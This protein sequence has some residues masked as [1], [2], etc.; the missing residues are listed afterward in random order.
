MYFPLQLRLTLFY[1]L[2]LGIAL[3]IFGGIVFTQAE[4]R[5]YSDLDNTL[6]SRA[7]SVELG[8]DML[9]MQHQ[10]PIIL[11]SISGS[12]TGGVAIEV[13][14]NQLH[15]LATSTSPGISQLGTGVADLGNSPVPWDRQAAQWVLAHP[16]SDSGEP[17]DMF[18]TVFYEGQHIR[19]YTV[20]NN[21]YG[22]NHIIQTARSEQDIEQS[23]A[24]LRTL[25][26]SGGGLVMVFALLG[27]WFLTRSLLISVRR[28]TTTA[29]RISDSHDFSQR[30]PEQASGGRDELTRLAATFNL[31]LAN[32]EEAYQRQ[33]RF[34]ADASHELRAPI[35]SIRCNLDLLAKTPGIAPEDAEA[36]L[37]DARAEAER[38]GRMVNDLLTL[39]HSDNQQLESR[40]Y[41][42][43]KSI[44]TKKVDLDSLLLE[45]YRQYRPSDNQDTTRGPRIIL[46]DIAPAQVYGD[47]DRLKQIL[48]A[49]LDNAVKY[50]PYEGTVSLSLQTEP[51]SA[52]LQV[53][54]TGIG[55]VPEDQPHIFERFY[56][57]DRARSRDR[58]GSGLGLAIVKSIVEEHGGTI[59]LES[60]P[61]KGSTF[62]VR[63]PLPEQTR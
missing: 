54:D 61:G 20:V 40:A 53:S 26:W 57:A 56:R 41:G 50:T 18:S 48:V 33:Q 34:V 46:Q 35:S 60:V 62:I 5:A 16:T 39:A 3:L 49:L 17:G 31:M 9:A 13:L 43:R 36:A 6:R 12:G 24:N 15:L 25:L 27:G 47:A 8:K 52:L 45:V 14:D 1:A 21:Q 38:M 55:I 59:S 10:P 2:L 29:Q 19:V 42:Y 22:L 7:A 23:L 37:N 63:L 30:V 51:E 4:Q 11:P 44:Y 32:L 28:I 58:G